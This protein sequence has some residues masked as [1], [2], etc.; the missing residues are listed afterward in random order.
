MPLARIAIQSSEKT[1][2]GSLAPVVPSPRF[3]ARLSVQ[4]TAANSEAS[5]DHCD[6]ETQGLLADDSNNAQP[7]DGIES[8]ADSLQAAG[9]GGI[10]WNGSHSTSHPRSHYSG[11]RARAPGVADFW[12]GITAELV[13]VSLGAP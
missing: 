3:P 10:F 7:F 12:D 11:W 2:S 1:P 13:A 9:N 5:Y 4:P 6:S 8:A